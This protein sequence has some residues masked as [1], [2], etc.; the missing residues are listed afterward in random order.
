MTPHG[1]TNQ[2]IIIITTT[3]KKWMFAHTSD[4]LWEINMQHPLTFS[5]SML[6]YNFMKFIHKKDAHHTKM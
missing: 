4:L 1:I 5:F 3:T 2:I 6:G